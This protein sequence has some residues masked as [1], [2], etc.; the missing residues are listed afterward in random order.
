[1]TTSF[2][3]GVRAFLG[4]PPQP[5]P[6]APQY[7]PLTLTRETVDPILLPARGDA[8]DFQL[9]AVFTWHSRSISMEELAYWAEQLADRATR[10]LFDRVA[11]TAREYP[12]HEARRLEA[13]LRSDLGDSYFHC[14]H[15]GVSLRFQVRVRVDPDERVREKLRPFWEQR[16][17][18]ECQQELDLLRV[19]LVDELTHEWSVILKKLEEDP[20]T[21]HAARLSE[22]QF[23]SVFGDFVTERRRVVQEITDLLQDAVTRHGTLGLGPSEYTKAWDDALKAFRRKYGLDSD[24]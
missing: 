11:D 20:S 21:P 9:H 19:K 22:E 7:G 3:D 16:I 12:P 14:T 5:R 17:K 18:M 6:A 13:R 8:F 1:M 2:M 24:I 4:T 23:A 10:T 15:D